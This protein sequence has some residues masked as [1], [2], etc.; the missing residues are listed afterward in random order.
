MTEQ[1]CD[2][3]IT[4]ELRRRVQQWCDCRDDAR[5]DADAANLIEELRAENTRLAAKAGENIDGDHVVVVLPRSVAID[6]LGFIACQ[7]NDLPEAG[8]RR[9]FGA[10]MGLG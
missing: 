5:L 3:D 6:T 10:A 9:A 4:T 2:H 1:T 8:L 7:G